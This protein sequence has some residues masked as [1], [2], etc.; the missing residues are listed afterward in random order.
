MSIEV[1]TVQKTEEISKGVTI[2]WNKSIKKKCIVCCFAIVSLLTVSF[3]ALGRVWLND[4]LSVTFNSLLVIVFAMCGVGY[5]KEIR[6][7]LN[8][9]TAT[10]ILTYIYSAI[11]IAMSGGGIGVI[12]AIILFILLKNNEQ[13]RRELKKSNQDIVL[14]T[15]K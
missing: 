1:D 7:T 3:I 9:I 14:E 12:P 8:V 4:P 2:E 6:K 13:L 5:F 10:V 15:V 11:N